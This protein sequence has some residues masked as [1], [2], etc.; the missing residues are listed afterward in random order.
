MKA[1]IRH[2]LYIPHLLTRLQL[3]LCLS[4]IVLA[5]GPLQALNASR[6]ASRSQLA[7]GRWVKI[8][9]SE[10]GIHQITYRELSRWGFSNPAAVTIYGYGGAMLP[11]TFS[12]DDP[13]DLEQIPSLNTGSKILFYAQGP[14]TWSYNAKTQE[15]DHETNT[16]STAGYYFLTDSK[17]ASAEEDGL[18]QAYATVGAITMNGDTITSMV[19]DAVQASVNFDTAGQITTDL[20]AAQPSKNQ[21]GDDYGM[22]KASSIG[23]E[24]YEQAAGFAAYVTG[25]T[26]AEVSGIAV[27]EDGKAADADLAASVTISI[28]AFQT[29]VDKAA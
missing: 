15:Y 2:T 20:T 4:L 26:P 17:S 14:V 7:D 18:A 12:D 11:E 9:V 24:W 21:L 29:L 10:S 1:I 8:A 3:W 25:K 16:Y 28:G 6:Y 22:R 13:D 23:K 27:T 5:T 19:I